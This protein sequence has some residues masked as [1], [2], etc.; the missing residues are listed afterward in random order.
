M[1]LLHLLSAGLLD[2]MGAAGRRRLAD[3]EALHE[4]LEEL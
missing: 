4:D 1:A 2:R 3:I